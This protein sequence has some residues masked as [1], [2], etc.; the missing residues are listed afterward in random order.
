M[1]SEMSYSSAL[2]IASSASFKAVIIYLTYRFAKKISAKTE[3][4]LELSQRLFE[5]TIITLVLPL[6]S[7][8]VAACFGAETIFYSTNRELYF[9]FFI[10]NLFGVIVG[11]NGWLKG[12]RSLLDSS[13]GFV[14]ITLIFVIGGYSYI[15]K[16][17]VENIPTSFSGTWHEVPD[18][19]IDGQLIIKISERNIQYIVPDY[20]E[21]YAWDIGKIEKQR[22][23]YLLTMINKKGGTA[24][25]HRL[26]H[27]KN[28]NEL[29]MDSRWGSSDPNKPYGDWIGEISR[30]YRGPIED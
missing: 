12:S 19:M 26:I 9:F 10:P 6:F 23:W 11:A 14:V 5:F 17:V 15:N 24:T 1:E 4:K 30:F 7:F 27:G 21:N 2:W 8:C 22:G 3:L 18:P 25:Q 29:R 28:A 13:S 16:E 20:Q